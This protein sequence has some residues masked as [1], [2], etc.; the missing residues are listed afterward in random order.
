RWITFEPQLRSHV[1][2]IEFVFLP[3]ASFVAGCVVHRMM[4]CTKRHGE[5]VAHFET[6]S[7][8]LSEANMMCLGRRASTNDARLL[9]D[10]P[11]VLLR[12]MPFGFAD[13]EHTFIDLR[14]GCR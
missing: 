8:W 1:E 7:P 14:A 6:K 4:N 9:D 13:G 10:K 3:P 12:A 11:Q 5:L 2:R